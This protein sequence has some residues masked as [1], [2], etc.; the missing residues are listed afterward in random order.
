MTKENERRIEK[1]NYKLKRDM[2][3]HKAL[4]CVNNFVQKCS[5]NIEVPV[6]ISMLPSLY[7]LFEGMTK[8]TLWIVALPINLAEA[9]IEGINRLREMIPE[10]EA[11]LNTAG[12][13]LL[14]PAGVVVVYAFGKPLA[15]ASRKIQRTYEEEGKRLDATMHFISN[16]N[17]EDENRPEKNGYM[18]DLAKNLFNQQ[19]NLGLPSKK[20]LEIIKRA[21]QLRE[22][23]ILNQRNEVKD[24]DVEHSYNE[25]REYVLKI[26]ESSNC[27][28]AFK[29][30]AVIVELIERE[31]V[32][33]VVP[34]NTRT[35]ETKKFGEMLKAKQMQ[36]V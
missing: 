1:I 35:K 12:Y 34:S 24:N 19:D 6:T 5:N 3:A 2:F 21:V 26:Y 10:G 4:G 28:K 17:A 15:K 7:K 13:L 9:N 18:F 27:P 29:D 25:L 31:L 33:Y 36:R 23:I 30:N 11:A 20:Y 22:T 16:I 8:G 32:R 14:L